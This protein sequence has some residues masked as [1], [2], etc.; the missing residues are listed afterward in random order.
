MMLV[1]LFGQKAPGFTLDPARRGYHVAYREG[2]VN[3]CPGCGRSHWHVG[4]LSAEC[5]FCGTALPLTDSLGMG[6]GLFRNRGRPLD[7]L[8]NAA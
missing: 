7:G 1:R 2:E 6:A 8:A 3:R 5:A 4:R